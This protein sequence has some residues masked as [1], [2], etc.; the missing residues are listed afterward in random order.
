MKANTPVPF[1]RIRWFQKKLGLEPNEL[2][3][4]D[5]YRSLFAEKKKEFSENFFQYFSEIP[6]TKLI[7]DHEERKEFLKK[8][9][10]HW[11][12]SLFKEDFNQRFL[13]YIWR[14]G[15]RHV[16]VNVDQRFISLGYS[17][18]RQFCHEIT[19]T[20]ILSADQ[21]S[22]LSVVDKMI[23]LCLLIET[24]AYITATSQCDMEVVRG[25]SH[26]VRNPLTIIGGN[27]LRLLKKVDPQNPVHRTY[28]TILAENKRLE[29]MVTDV[30]I[31]SDMFE[32]EPEFAEVSIESLISG[33]LDRLKGTQ[34]IEDVKMDIDLS[35]EFPSVQGVPDDLETMFYH[36]LENSL[37]AVDPE[38]PYIRISSKLLT[39]A[40]SFVE[41]EIFNNGRP[42]SAEEIDNLFVP[43]YSSKP[44]GTGFGLPIAQ[45]AA[46]RSLGDLSLEPVPD[47]GTRCVIKLPIPVEKR[48]EG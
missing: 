15:L 9:W 10:A 18:I 28:K 21:D 16:D 1:E 48:S 37:E 39:S 38:N 25:I 12:E 4:L 8:A 33:A 14:S 32:K 47:Q 2:A 6:E 24:H 36:L 31:Y 23:D 40:P 30:A 13:S 34:A 19:K 46:R 44:Y 11:F 29:G 43:F 26:Q 3:K 45:L 5:Q 17:F 22:V 41:I 27:I 7:L 20:K 35:P 42:M